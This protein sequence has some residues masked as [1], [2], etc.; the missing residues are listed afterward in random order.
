MN[1]GRWSSLQVGVNAPGTP[2]ITTFL[3]A[4]MSAAGTS[5]FSGDGIRAKKKEGR[6]RKEGKNIKEGRKE[7]RNIKEGRKGGREEG[8]E[9]GR[10]EEKKYGIEPPP[11]P[12]PY[13]T[14][15]SSTHRTRHR[16]HLASSR[17]FRASICCPVGAVQSA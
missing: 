11:R 8:R 2:Q 9:E 12:L 5:Y 14:R 15:R 10:K 17:Y 1:E 3:P 7:A 13:N 6:N 16:S 4:K